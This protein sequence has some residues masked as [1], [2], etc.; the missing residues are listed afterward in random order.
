M[1]DRIT[2]FGDAVIAVVTF[3]QPE[4][5]AAHQAHLAVP[6]AVLADPERRLYA[7]LGSERGT[8]RQV[9]SLGTLRMYGRLLRKGRRLQ[10]PTEDVQ[11]LG[12]DAII[13]RDGTLGYLSLPS[14]PDARPSVDELLVALHRTDP[15]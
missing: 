14:T 10:K 5:L 13:G 9:W 2:E 6:F 11:Q 12:A 4:R 8:R 7:L 1:R 15:I 3:A